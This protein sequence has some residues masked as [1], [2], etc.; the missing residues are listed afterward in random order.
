[1]GLLLDWV[2][3]IDRHL[4]GLLQHYGNG[5]YGI[6]F[7]IVFV[8]TGLIIMPFLPGDSLIFASS[9][10]AGA[11]LLNIQQLILVLVSAAILGD[12]LN[13]AVGRQCGLYWL[14]KPPHW[15]RPEH[16]KQTQDFFSQ[17]GRKAIIMARFLPIFRTMMPFVAGMASMPYRIFL[18]I[19][20][21]GGIGWVGTMAGLGYYFG[22]LDIVRHYFTL[23]VAGIIILSLLPALSKFWLHR[24]RH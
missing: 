17:H 7:A 18:P 8:E 19:D 9:A 14:A 22:N 6:V 21:L 16:V 2:L 24:V 12:N 13:Y 11:G 10:L 5:F 1:M 4:A 3:H 23:C 20:L 15:L